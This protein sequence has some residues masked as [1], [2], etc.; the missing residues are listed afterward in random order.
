MTNVQNAISVKSIKVSKS[1]KIVPGVRL[2][3][4]ERKRNQ[5]SNTRHWQ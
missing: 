4:P 2:F 3:K 1:L 5:F